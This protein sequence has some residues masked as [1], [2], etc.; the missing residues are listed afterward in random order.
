YTIIR[1]FFQKSFSQKSV[2]HTFYRKIFGSK[3]FR[4][5]FIK[6]SFVFYYQNSHKCKGRNLCMI[7][8]VF[9]EFKNGSF[10]FFRVCPGVGK[11][12]MCYLCCRLFLHGIQ[13]QTVKKLHNLINKY[14][15]IVARK[16]KLLYF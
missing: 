1:F 7:A 13:R 11:N 3:S 6:G 5:I 2:K 14:S 10:G 12:Q 4:N 15:K 9:G 8:I 16:I